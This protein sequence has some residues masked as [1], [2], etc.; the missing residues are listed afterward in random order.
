MFLS[1]TTT[2]YKGNLDILRK[3]F[4]SIQE[5]SRDF[6]H[7]IILVDVES[8]KQ[9]EKMIKK[10]FPEIIFIP[11]KENIGYVKA[12]NLSIKKTQKTSKY[13][14]YL[15]AGSFYK[16]DSIKKM[17]AFME[18][19]LK[20]GICA[21]KLFETNGN[22]I[23]S[24]FRFYKL[25]TPAFRRLSFLNKF[26]FVQKD[27]DKFLMKDY[28]KKN[29][30]PVDW[31]MGTS[32]LIRREALSDIGLHDERFYHYFSDI[33][34]CRCFW[35]KKWEVWFL[36]EAEIIFYHGK[37][38]TGGLSS[39]FKKFTRIHIKDGIKYFWKWKKISQMSKFKSQ[40]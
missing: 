32:N 36:P 31:F 7:E 35:Q 10:E 21:P 33:D 15:K 14:L 23:N 17:I 25:W 20:V 37:Q 34:W 40:N 39:L 16:K 5:E 27:L 1:I 4:R 2:N 29:P 3:S 8:E 22:L 30:S 24:C 18:K 19:N 28:D 26:L 9:T 11:T 13:I 6:E 12:V 38:S